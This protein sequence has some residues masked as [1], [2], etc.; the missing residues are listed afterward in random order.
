MIV[1]VKFAQIKINPLWID[2]RSK[3][4]DFSEATSKFNWKLNFIYRNMIFPTRRVSSLYAISPNFQKPI[5]L[6][7]HNLID[8]VRI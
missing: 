2:M 7:I 3:I 4:S 6:N 1:F 5:H 8:L